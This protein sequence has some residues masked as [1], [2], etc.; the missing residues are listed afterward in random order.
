MDEK[1]LVG[2]TSESCGTDNIGDRKYICIS[3]CLSY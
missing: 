2:N 3:H 1:A